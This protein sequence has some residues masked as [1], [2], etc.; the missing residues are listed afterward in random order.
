MTDIKNFF[1]KSEYYSVKFE[2]YFPIYEKLFSRFRNKK[3]VFVDIGVFSGGSLFMWK[4]YF[5]E[6]AK[7]IG[8]DLNP[9]A[10]KFEK[11]G[12]DIF[13]GD[14]SSEKFWRDFFTKV[15]PVDIVL[16]DGG[17]TNFQQINT[18]IACS[19]NVNDDGLIVIEDTWHSYIKKKYYN[20]SKRS[21]IN[22]CKKLID[23]NN[24]RYPN[25]GK[26]KFS[27]NNYIFSIEF[28]ESMV[29]F[30]I[31]QKMCLT[32][33]VVQNNG[34]NINAEDMTHQISSQNI[35][36]TDSLLVRIKNK[37]KFLKMNFTYLVFLINQKKLKKFFK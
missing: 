30:N 5:G 20:P 31:N 2:N 4:E 26:F 28:F 32:N 29:A 15:G 36:N 13:I 34:K 9:G 18:V 33:K 27:L 21:F 37:F 25:I 35:Y 8:V 24:F 6:K 22:F 17:H 10:K 3:I 1:Y 14:Q 16:D 11:Y 7:I 12:F 23:D 19:R